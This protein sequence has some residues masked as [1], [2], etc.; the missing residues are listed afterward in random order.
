MPTLAVRNCPDFQK[1]AKN[2]FADM[3][4]APKL[5]GHDGTNI[6]IKFVKRY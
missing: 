3:Y 5:V 6:T 1:V 4:V 2:T